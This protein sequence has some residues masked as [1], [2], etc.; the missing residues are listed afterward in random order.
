MKKLRQ[1]TW[2]ATTAVVLAA[3][4]YF[5]LR[6]FSAYSV[7]NTHFEPIAPGSVN[8]VGI[9]PG[10]GYRVIIA[11][12][13]AQLVETQ[14]GF[15]GKESEAG[16]ATEGAIKKRVPI[17][18]LLG[19]LRGDGKS[20]GN[21]VMIMNNIQENEDWPPIRVLWKK[22]DIEK[23]IS[24]DPKLKAKL[25]HD[26]NV[27][28]DGTPIVPLNR[29]SLENGIFVVAPV[30]LTVNVNG[31]QTLV[32]GETMEPFKP[33]LIKAVEARYKDKSRVDDAMIAGYYGDEAKAALASPAKRENLASS[34]RSMYSKEK[35]ETRLETPRR[36]LANATVVVN[37]RF[38]TDARYTSYKGNDGKPLNDLTVDL[39]DEGRRRLW[40][41]SLNRVGD[42]ILLIANDVAIAAP[43]IQH[44]LA[45]GELTIRQM[46]DEVLVREAVDSIKGSRSRSASK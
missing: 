5:G 25:E 21:F 11:N 41:F 29:N 2:I 22:D 40:K 13:V 17:R 9:N 35:M 12:D 1:S 38:I 15:E 46:P 7:G 34:L 8:L 42:Q 23:A 36:M 19:V 6:A 45:L 3:G 14:G 37:E 24:G 26:L 4:G 30:E 10:A 31:K 28:L 39:T 16:G 18:E 44:E 27:R 20:L 32:R 43:R 33:Q